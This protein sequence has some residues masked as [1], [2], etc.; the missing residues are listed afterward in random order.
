VF[1]DDFST[2]YSGWD[3]HV[4]PEITTDYND[5]RYLIAVN[6]PGIDVWATPGIPFG[7]IDVQIDVDIVQVAGSPDDE[8][9][10]MCKHSTDAGANFWFFLM[11][12]DGS[13]AGGKVQ[14]NN[15]II[16]TDDGEFWPDP[17]RGGLN[18]PVHVRFSCGQQ[19]ASVYINSKL[20]YIFWDEVGA[21]LTHGEVGL[22]AGTSKQGGLKV[23]F[24]NF[25]IRKL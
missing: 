13:T 6:Q 23:L 3:R 21:R 7:D 1:S 2:V 19:S 8:F 5:G 9:G 17:A 20:A 4:S 12:G 18:R 11:R 25:V 15:R 10:V 16:L 14:K 24:D 22:L